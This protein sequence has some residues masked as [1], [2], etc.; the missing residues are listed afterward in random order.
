VGKLDA[1]IEL[2]PHYFEQLLGEFARRPRLGIAGGVLSE[3]DGGD[4]WH[5]TS[6][7]AHH[8]RG[9]LKLYARTCFERIGGVEERLGWDTIDEVYARMA[10]F[11]TS[12]IAGLEARHH[13]PVATRGGALRG[14]ARL[15]RCA[16]ILRY[17]IWWVAPRSLKVAGWRPYG[18]SGAAYLY[19]YLRAAAR[20]EERVEDEAF[21]RFV[22]GE[23][24]GRLGRLGGGSPQTGDQGTKVPTIFMRS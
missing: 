6:G 1:D 7:P 8:V 24:R 16:Y 19:G 18:L 11:E 3:C 13:R 22:A 17:G 23:L 12:S 15:G 10:G 14:R 20:R 4:R 21:R 2:P 9:A 5:R